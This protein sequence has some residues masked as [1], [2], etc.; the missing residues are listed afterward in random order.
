MRPDI[1][2]TGRGGVV[3]TNR[4][5]HS[6]YRGIAVVDGDYIIFPVYTDRHISAWRVGDIA[7]CAEVVGLAVDSLL[8]ENLRSLVFRIVVVALCADNDPAGLLHAGIVEII[9]FSV[10]LIS[11]VRAGA[12]FIFLI[13]IVALP[14][15]RSPAVYHFGG[16]DMEAVVIIA[17]LLYA[18]DAVR[19][20]IEI[21]GGAVDGVCSAVIRSASSI[22]IVVIFAN[23][24]P[25]ALDGT[26]ARGTDL[27]FGIYLDRGKIIVFFV[28]LLQSGPQITFAGA[29]IGL[30]LP[31]AE[32]GE[33]TTVRLTEIKLLR[34]FHIGEP[35]LY[36]PSFGVKQ[37]QTGLTVLFQRAWTARYLYSLAV[38]IIGVSAGSYPFVFGGRSRSRRRQGEHH[39]KQQK[40][41]YK[42]LFL[43][44][45]VFTPS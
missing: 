19:V 29:V 8:A 36:Q 16:L 39:T 27:T 6:L 23:V 45:V 43:F 7:F 12:P 31:G 37:E 44:H 14:L 3:Q 42:E 28:V 20:F 2:G 33:E 38:V 32:I 13:E 17:D 22:K 40:Q 15:V 21:V 41:G 4:A 5:C 30:P 26:A 1:E 18:G 25:G 34:A 24:F 10:D 9:I 11:A 35:I